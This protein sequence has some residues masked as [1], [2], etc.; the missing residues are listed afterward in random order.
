MNPHHKLLYHWKIGLSVFALFA[1]FWSVFLQGHKASGPDINTRGS[2]QKV[3]LQLRGPDLL[4]GGVS[5]FNTGGP[6]KLREL[7]GKIVLLDFWAYC[8][9]NCHHILPDLARLEEKYKNQLVVIGVHSAKFTAEKDSENIRRKVREYGIKHPVVNDADLTLWNRF[10][11]NSW[12]TL[13]LIDPEGQPVG[14]IAG[15]GHYAI[16]DRAIGELVKRFRGKS[17]DESPVKF[18]PE[19]EKPDNTPLL[20]PGKVLADPEGQRLFIADT[21]HNRIVLTDLEGKTPTL[22]GGGS[23]GLTDGPYNKAEWNRPQGMTLVGETLYVADT[24]NHAIRAVDLKARTVSTIAGTG[25]QSQSHGQIR[26]GSRADQTAL[27]SPWDLVHPTDTRVLYIAMAGPHQI[28]RLDLQTGL[29][30]VLAG[31]G[32]EN[33]V[34]GPVQKA[35]FAQPSGLALNGTNLYVADSEVSA[36]RV[37]DLGGENPHLV[38]T[39]VGKGLFDFGDVDG[40]GP[41]VRLQHCLGVAYGNEKLYVADTYNNKVKVCDP[42]TRSVKTLLGTGKPGVASNP[43]EF[44]Q[45]GGLSLAGSKLY[46]ADTNNHQIRV[47]DVESLKVASLDLGSLTPPSTRV[48]KPSFPN[49]RLASPVQARVA[50]GKSLTLDVSLPIP[51]GFKLNAE[52]SMPVLVETPGRNGLLAS[53]YPSQG[54][55]VEPPSA[56]FK[57]DVPLARD[58]VPGEKL[59][60]KL[61]IAAFVCN[62]GSNLCT[63]KSYLWPIAIEF[64]A[65][66]PRSIPIGEKGQ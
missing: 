12:P 1:A 41:T 36:L 44:Y 37:L 45:P 34:D 64:V 16:L 27:N 19:N 55:K 59:E 61:S 5:W 14:S 8:C 56:R 38:R 21:G 42:K 52:G 32:I 7:R 40:V 30:A 65:N 57:L 20:F 4:D 3:S 50:S 54:T 58:S 6:I 22:I 62:E 28:W 24:E 39:I 9:I 63:I 13:V 23:T 15:E 60:L 48:R 29:I 43:A 46:V 11:V 33:I 17:L 10:D 66:G 25:K 53:T 18:F 49:A 35:A 51:A 31:S 47:I 2:Y 26:A